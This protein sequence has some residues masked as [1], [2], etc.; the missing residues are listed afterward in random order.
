M[1]ATGLGRRARVR[2]LGLA[3]LAAC[4]AM[5][6]HAAPPDRDA[7]KAQVAQRHDTAVKALQEWIALPSIAAEDRNPAQGAEY[8]A[9]L[10]REAG[11]QHVEVV[12]TGG[13]PGVFATLDAGAPTTVGVYYMYD[14]KQYDPAEWT[15]PP[16][17]ARLIDKPG[18][19]KAVVGRGATNQKGP[20]MA[21]LTALHA[22]R[23]AKQTMPV[24]LVLV[25]E[26]E[27]E[28]GSPNIGKLVLRPDIQAALKKSIGVF[29]PMGLQDP[30]G[31][32]T[33][34]LGA[35]GVVELELVADGKAWG[36]G[37]SKDVHSSLKAM[38]DSPAWRLVKALDTLVSEDGNTVTI[39]G[40]PKPA[41]LSAQDRAMIARSTGARDE[42]TARKSLG[43]PHWIDDLSWEKANER[44]VSQPTVN[45]QGLVG[46]YT[47]VGGKTVLPHR[48]VAK[49]DMRLVPP[50]TR[51][52]AVA[53][54]K[55][56]L[57]KRGYGDIAVNVSGGYDPTSTDADSRLIQAQVAVLRR[58]GVEPLMWPRLA[59]SYPGFVFTQP[60]LSL[61]AGHFGLGHGGGAHAPDEFFLI[62]SSNPKVQGFDGAVMSYV[63]YLYELGSSTG[64]AAAAK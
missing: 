22:I 43:V 33:V 13:K 14:V 6:A 37:P 42:A 56:H 35:K 53:A 61:P 55:A 29:M 63:D 38:V 12:D 46:G 27:E 52:G 62:E 9:R 48:A 17:E 25:A 30:A 24:N 20:E 59:G 32:V 5:T 58:N 34:N 26:G 41:P 49:I 21:F 40:F 18:L 47:G 19:G 31:A 3:T 16:L 51:D 39:D 11:F 4:M 50:M 1:A 60:P 64:S 36:R 8:M 54:L 44:L 7:I 45:I 15:S 2:A 10:A 23:D 57:A 28:I